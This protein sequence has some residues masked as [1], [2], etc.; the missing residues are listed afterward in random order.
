[1][2]ALEQEEGMAAAELG[3]LPAAAVPV[4]AKALER[5]TARAFQLANQAGQQARTNR[6]ALSMSGIGGCKREAAYRLAGVPPTDV[7][8]SDAEEARQAMIGT[9][10]HS[11]LLPQFENVLAHAD[12]ELPVELEVEV[13]LPD[14]GTRRLV[15]PGT[16]DC[17]SHVMGGGVL[18]LKTV[19]AYRIGQIDHDGVKVSHRWQV[20]GY[21]TALRQLGLPVAWVAWLYV[22]RSSG[23]VLVAIEPFGPDE[24]EETLEYV[25]RLWEM[26]RAP[27]YAPRSERGPGLSWVC[28]GC[29]WLRQCWGPDARPGDSAALKVHDE[30]E[31][32][33]AARKFKE[34]GDQIGELTKD[35]EKW[36]AMVGRPEMG[37]YRDEQ[38]E[39]IIKY[40]K[41]GEEVDKKAAVEQLALLGGEVPMRKRTGNRLVQWGRKEPEG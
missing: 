35:R 41:D 16:A 21:A 39:M 22:D 8:L 5:A 29:A 9:W 26:A 38:G 19:N 15:V 27:D 12:I 17:Y 2:T 34:L 18:D 13:P 24:E 37:A 23:E 11:G 31:I 4:L 32:A 14:G 20:R 7:E 25:R 40:Q 3:P 28:D 30:P 6:W 36:G 33:F 1:M 10:I